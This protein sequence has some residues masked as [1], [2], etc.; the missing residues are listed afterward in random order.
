MAV[1]AD[2]DLARRMK[3][4]SLHGISRDGWHRFRENGTW[5]YRILAAGYKYNMTDV[6]AALGLG[7][8][9]RAETM[10]QKRA[11]IS[12][13]YRDALCDVEGLELPL[14]SPDRIHSWHL[15]PIRVV[16][17]P[18]GI[19]R[20][21][22]IEA[23]R[24][25]GIGTSVH[26]RPLHLHPFYKEEF[27]WSAVDFPSATREWERLVSLPIF[28]DMSKQDMDYVVETIR[29]QWASDAARIN[30]PQEESIARLTR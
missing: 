3:L 22:L 14:D 8:L 11:A 17:T 16:P 29:A 28:P 12:R 7:Q 5:D 6:A 18:G 13:A 24:T 2:E 19:G 23:L 27:G 25:R 20:D 21:G 9:S 15:F 1:T 26:W 10:R 30:C 4:M